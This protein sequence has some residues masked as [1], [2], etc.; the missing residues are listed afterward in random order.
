[1]EKLG[2]RKMTHELNGVEITEMWLTNEEKAV[3]EAMRKGADVQ[4]TLSRAKDVEEVDS[5]MNLFSGMDI[6]SSWIN[7]NTLS[8]GAKYISFVKF[9]KNIRVSC[10]IDL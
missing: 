5:V 10:F 4:I 9:F 2:G 3:V 6:K 1:L 7:Q 8:D